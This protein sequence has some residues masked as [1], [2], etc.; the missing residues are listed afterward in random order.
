MP[1]ISAPLSAK[2]FNAEGRLEHRSKRVRI[3]GGSILYVSKKNSALLKFD[4]L[5]CKSSQCYL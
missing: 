4:P 3:N 1:F 5:H 2:E